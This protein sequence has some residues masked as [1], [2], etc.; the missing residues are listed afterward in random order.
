MT[1][2]PT[3][4]V[5]AGPY[6]RL[7]RRPSFRTFWIGFTLSVIGD[8]MTR[9]A[10]TWIVYERTGSAHALGLLTV[11]FTA[12][13]L[14][15]G[16]LAGPLLDRFD[17]RRVMIADNVV[18]G[19]CMGCVPLLHALG[20]LSLG[21]LYAAAAIYSFLMMI[22]LAGCPA[23]L[24]SLADDRDLPGA[25]ALET[26]SYTVAGVVG[27]PLA[28]LLI[29]RIGAPWIVALDAVSYLVFAA[30]LARIRVSVPAVAAPAPAASR[31]P[32][33][34]FRLFLRNPVLRSTTLMFMAF[35]IGFGAMMVWLPFH[36]DRLGDGGPGTF[37]LL[38]GVLAA[39]QCASAVLAGALVLPV[40]PGAAIGI[41]Q[42]LS[43][44]SLLLMLA[45][46]DVAGAALALLLL[47]V[48]SAPL[49]VWAQTLRMQ[50]IPPALRGRAFALLRTL[51]QG[52]T[53]IGGAVAG[54][55]L[56]GAGTGIVIGATA[57]LMALPGVVG[58]FVRGLRRAGQ[59]PAG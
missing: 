24:P 51:M 48:F 14:L 27:A 53:P 36:A 21:H 55:A 1:A 6:G 47:G 7:L 40:P 30:A 3:S 15:G 4:G 42:A 16:L 8:A 56:D 5:Q 2:V 34:A 26:L 18:R 22:S 50:V 37:G 9:V 33:E 32:G 11:A 39:G 31:G 58:C 28:G 43:G 59:S 57:T 35:N 49:T 38:L 20:M 41:A 23:L 25:N 54:F 17:R 10:F 46:R 44:A 45:R 19:L 13:V 52:A 12:P 29:A